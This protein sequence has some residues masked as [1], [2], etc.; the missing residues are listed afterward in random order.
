MSSSP[1]YV[2]CIVLTEQWSELSYHCFCRNCCY[3]H[4][5]QKAP[6][7]ANCYFN[8]QKITDYSFFSLFPIY[9]SLSVSV[10]VSVSRFL[11]SSV[12]GG[13]LQTSSG[14]L[15][16]GEYDDVDWEEEK[17]LERLACEGDD[18]IPPKIIVSTLS[19]HTH[20]HSL[21]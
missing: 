3:L 10:C 15:D 21:T 5:Q 11:W 16:E 2:A 1:T 20:S 13:D 4:R 12:S 6:E 18:F 19:N 8:Q 14:T 9:L 17:E 7:I